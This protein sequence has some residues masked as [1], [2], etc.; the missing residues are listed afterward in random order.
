M[1]RTLG[2]I[3][4][5]EDKLRLLS[6]SR[7]YFDKFS[8]LLRTPEHIRVAK[9]STRFRDVFEVSAHR[10]GTTLQLHHMPD[11]T[12][13]ELRE[14]FRLAGKHIEHLTCEIA[15]VDRDF[16]I[17]LI[18]S[19][20]P[21]LK[22]LIFY[23]SLND[24]SIKKLQHLKCLRSLALSDNQMLTG[25]NINQFSYITEL[26]LC[27][28]NKLTSHNLV[29]ILQYLEHLSRLDIRES[30]RPTPDI[31][32][33]LAIH[34]QKI[35]VLK[36]SCPNVPFKIISHL[37]R[38][39]ELTL[40]DRVSSCFKKKSMLLELAAYRANQ[41]QLLEIISRDTL[42]FQ[43]MVLISHL[44]N[45]RVLSITSNL[46]VDDEALNLF[47]NL[48][49]LEK[50]TLKEC[51][52]V[53]DEGLSRLLSHCKQLHYINVQFCLKIT[54]QFAIGAI[55]TLTT[56]NTERKKPLELY[57]HRTKVDMSVLSKN[58]T[59]KEAVANSL[60]KVVPNVTQ[61][62]LI[63]QVFFNYPLHEAKSGDEDEGI[64]LTEPKLFGF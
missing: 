21:Q 37:P 7:K 48:I 32:T 28:C 13:W 27:G 1:A 12:S 25:E 16:L 38:L 19:F 20:C 9:V 39:S 14:F 33:A 34:C 59:Y 40:V 8:I 58:A 24:D 45:L 3:N 17:P 18:I 49:K 55:H 44:E 52:A 30:V 23:N 6:I 10:E 31:Y 47:C 50:L 61:L 56:E 46:A 57:V 64:D 5:T 4:A 41:M 29:G 2:T 51:K 43:H 62:D 22:A 60:I 63:Y 36:M 54:N 42:R 11:M 53:S 26:N 15:L 35:E